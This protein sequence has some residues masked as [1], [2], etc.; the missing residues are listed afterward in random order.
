MNTP[1]DTVRLTT[2]CDFE[3]RT[4]AQWK[5]QALQSLRA[6]VKWA[7][8]D[9]SHTRS[10]DSSGL[11]ALLAINE[12]CTRYHGQVRLINPSSVVTQLLEL[13]RMHRVFV[14]VKGAASPASGAD[15]PILIAEDE[16]LILNVAT[17]SLKPLGRPIITAQDG[18]EAI[19][20][21][22]RHRPALILL[23]YIM[24]LMDGT[25]TL[26]H[27]KSDDAT[28]D[29]PVIIMSANEKIAR[30]AYENFEGASC[31]ITK[32]FSPAALRSEVHRLIQAN[33]EAAV[34]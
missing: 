5:A 33:M 23:D 16:S 1:S 22:R 26:R 14:I 21:A 13:T 7:E 6:G 4:A 3:Q 15:R 9:M 24:P 17:L 2:P 10:M 25:E 11:T 27:L 20:M 19:D 32:P 34:V 8:V 28:R 12:A 30:G 31:F 29:I 18:Q